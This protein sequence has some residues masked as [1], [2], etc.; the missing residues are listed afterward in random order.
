MVDLV[1]ADTN[2][3]GELNSTGR[4]ISCESLA[5]PTASI[6]RHSGT[7]SQDWNSRRIYRGEDVLTIT[8]DG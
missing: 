5:A 4:S 3:A 1:Y 2:K 7:G 6:L 8:Q